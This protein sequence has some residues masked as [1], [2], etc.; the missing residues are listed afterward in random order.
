MS[1]FEF[2]P[3]SSGSDDSDN[4]FCFYDDKNSS[5]KTQVLSINPNL[6][7]FIVIEFK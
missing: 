2:E 3:C 1:H 5:K 4:E 6:G 7:N